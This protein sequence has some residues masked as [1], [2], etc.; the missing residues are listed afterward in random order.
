[1]EDEIGKKRYS[2]RRSRETTRIQR[3]CC[4]CCWKR[5]QRWHGA[6]WYSLA[7]LLCTKESRPVRQLQITHH[8]PDS[9]STLDDVVSA[10]VHRVWCGIPYWR[11]IIYFP[12]DRTGPQISPQAAASILYVMGISCDSWS[13]TRGHW[14]QE[15][16]H[17]RYVLLSAKSV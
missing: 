15:L 6:A 12:A 10:C 8:I 9:H 3:C 7:D 2:S 11:V 14:W 5:W 4:R 13:V 16:T 17:F 1:V